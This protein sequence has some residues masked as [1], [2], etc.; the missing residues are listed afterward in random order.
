[1]RIL[2]DTNFIITCIKQKID[3]LSEP[4]EFLL[5][6]EVFEELEKISKR[7]G[8]KSDDKRAANLALAIVKNLERIKLCNADVDRGIIEYAKSN[9]DVVVASLDRKIK[10]KLGRAAVIIDKKSIEII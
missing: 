2:L 6:E 3:F 8:E 5:P 10:K 7:P 1:M 4:Y 9:K